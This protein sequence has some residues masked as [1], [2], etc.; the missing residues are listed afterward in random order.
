MNFGATE[1]VVLHKS[2]GTALFIADAGPDWSH[3]CVSSPTTFTAG[4]GGSG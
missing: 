3:G 4:G 2:S 1:E